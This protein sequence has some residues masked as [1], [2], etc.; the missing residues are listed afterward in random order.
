MA[1]AKTRLTA[2]KYS[3]LP[4]DVFWVSGPDSLCKRGEDDYLYGAPDPV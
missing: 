1:T 3:K 2:G 4:E